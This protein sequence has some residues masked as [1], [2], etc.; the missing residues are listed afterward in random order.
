MIRT[1]VDRLLQMV[2]GELIQGDQSLQIHGV[3]TDSRAD[4]SGRL[5]VP[6]IGERFD[7]HDFIQQAFENGAAAALWQKNRPLPDGLAANLPLIGVEDTLQ[8]LQNLAKSYR[9]TLSA[10]VIGVTGSN[11]KTS[12]KDLITSVLS[13]TFRVQKTQGNLNNHIGLPL[14]VL[15]LQ[16]DTEV[17]VLEMG[18]SGF[19]EI[20]LLADIAAPQIGV[21]TNIGEAHIEYLGSREGIARAKFELIEHLPETGLALLFG[22]EPLLRSLAGKAPCSVQWFG[23]GEP[24]DFRAVNVRALGLEGT[25]FTVEGS[26]VEYK[27]PVPGSH[28]VGNALAAIAIATRLGMK[29][30]AIASGL[31]KASLS[32]MRMEVTARRD[33]GFIVNDAYNASP[34]SM[35]AALTMLAN[36][37]DTDCRVAVLGDMLELGDSSAAMHRQIGEYTAKLGID[38]LIT[39]GSLAA[40]ISFGARAAGMPEAQIVHTDTK[41]QALTYL[42]SLLKVKKK[43]VILVKASRGMKLEEIVT[44][45]QA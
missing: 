10:T 35:Q 15:Q 14:M 7:A 21:I 22:D 26:S 32:A 17:A 31:S 2:N 45:L 27:I 20:A 3:S 23:F 42:H 4:L 11:G 12:T 6:I 1:S 33:G 30:E 24:N 13:E 5:F 39:I 8:A 18:M 28:Q 43:P 29:E 44:G 36:T 25:S 38:Q 9:Q 16:A 19:G 34:T 41:A 37:P 40:N